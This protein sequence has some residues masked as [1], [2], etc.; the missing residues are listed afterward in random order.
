M[1]FAVVAAAAILL[2]ACGPGPMPEPA[3][4]PA[5]GLVA[6]PCDGRGALRPVHRTYCARHRHYVTG[7]VAAVL[8]EAAERLNRRHP[9]AAILYMEASWPRGEKPMPPHVSHGDGRQI[10]L[11]LFYETLDGRPLARPPT[12]SGYGAFEPPRRESERVC[13]PDGGH[14]DRPDPPADRTWRLD[15]ERTAE[16]IRSLSADPRVRRIFVEP[17]LKQRLGFAAD[18]K[19]RFAGCAV[20]RHDDHLHIDFH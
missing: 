1:R 6:L 5:A 20:A 10:D 17:H 4:P 16:L 13:V 19:V 15:D 2:A 12:A 8:R 11:A 18:P 3:Q 9:D 14:H 7:T